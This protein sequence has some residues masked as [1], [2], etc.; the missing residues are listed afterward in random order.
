MDMTYVIQTKLSGIGGPVVRNLSQR[1]RS[2]DND[3]GELLKMFSRLPNV[4]DMV[5]RFM[6]DQL[7]GLDMKLFG[8]DYKIVDGN[9]IATC[10]T[11]MADG[12]CC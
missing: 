3:R 10:E 4:S 1:P 2:E 6:T 7:Y 8:Y 12:T 5:Q 9:L 11:Y